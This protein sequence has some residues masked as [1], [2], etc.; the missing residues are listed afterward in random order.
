MS[1]SV[2]PTPATILSASPDAIASD[3]DGEI[4][5]IS[6][7]TARY[8]G[9]DAV[10]SEIWRRLQAPTRLADLC[11]GLREAFDGDPDTIEREAIAFVTQLTE[12]GLV[13]RVG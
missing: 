7:A 5:L 3:V 12:R 4:V 10:G 9:L 11:S 1:Q 2:A 8:F 13:N 6:V